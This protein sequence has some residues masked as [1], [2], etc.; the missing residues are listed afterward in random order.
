VGY[1]ADITIVDPNLSRTVD[2]GTLES[3]ADYSPYEG[4]PLEGWP[5]AT[6]VRGRRIMS[7]GAILADAR[8]HPQGH[9]LFRT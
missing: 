1:D 8:D 6:Y 4:M 7:G 9:Y 2:P 3:F 5:T